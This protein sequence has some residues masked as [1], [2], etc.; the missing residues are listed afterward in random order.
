VKTIYE[1]RVRAI[2]PKNLRVFNYREN[3]ESRWVEFNVDTRD[4]NVRFT[5][6]LLQRLSRLLGTED[7][8]VTAWEGNPGCCY[9]E[10]AGGYVLAQKVSFGR[11]KS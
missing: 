11:G 5:L 7:I 6:V 4:M 2:V 9:S 3:K 8:E 1:K 10:P